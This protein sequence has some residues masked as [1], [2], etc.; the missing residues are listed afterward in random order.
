MYRKGTRLDREKRVLVFGAGDAGEM[1]ARDM[2]ENSF[3]E[4]EPIGFVDDDRAKVGQR[5]HGLRVLGT[6]NDLGRIFASER[7][8]EVLVAIVGAQ[9][10]TIRGIVRALQPYKVPITTL[11]NLRDLVSGKATLREIRA[12][13]VEDLLERAPVELDSEPVRRLIG[14][15]LVLV[16]GAGGSIGSELCRQIA[17]LGP[18][19]LTLLERYENG[20]YA[21]ANDLERYERS[22]RIQPVIG[23]V[24]DADRVNAVIAETRPNL[25]F[26]AAA[27]KHVPLMELNVCEAVKNNVIGTRTVVEAAERFGCERFVLI[28]TDKAVNPVSVMGATKRVGELLVQ[29]RNG[30]GGHR[31]AVR[32]G[33]VL[34]T[35]GSVIPKFLD[36]IKAGGPVTVTHPEMRRY[37][38]LISEAAQLVLHAA[39]RGQSGAVYVLEMGEQINML[40]MAQDVIRLSGLIPGEEISITFTGVRPGEKLVEELVGQ[41]ETVEPLEA[42]KIFR[43]RPGMLPDPGVLA[44]TVCELEELAIQGDA[45]EVVNQLAEV[46]PTFKP[47]TTP[48]KARRPSPLP[49]TD[50][51]IAKRTQSTS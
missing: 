12:L 49:L 39:A 2:K 27:H 44:K 14:G 50:P 16:T 45:K 11:P 36:Q 43:V 23:D 33:N 51:A 19:S 38:M 5:I 22:I 20:L 46:V 4:C 6:R 29:C 26:H 42:G 30:S 15:S 37:F 25:I 7:P 21:I 40:E 9:P 35:T 34:G 13:S 48:V 28:S 1:I 32:L 17:T 47:T 3:Y 8:D 41:D 10:S 24:T 31:M 18:R